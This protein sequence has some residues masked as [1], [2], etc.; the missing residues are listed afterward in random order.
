[1]EPPFKKQKIADPLLAY[2]AWHP[3]RR[4]TQHREH[5]HPLP[6]TDSKYCMVCDRWL[7]NAQQMDEHEKTKKHRKNYFTL[8]GICENTGESMEKAARRYH[9]Y[10]KA[11]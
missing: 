3:V 11:S 7:G 2:P 8:K 9:G 4:G 1:M 10:S 5:A 6:E